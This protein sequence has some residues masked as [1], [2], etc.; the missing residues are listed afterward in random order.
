MATIGAPTLAG[1]PE[2][3]PGLCASATAVPF[4]VEDEAAAFIKSLDRFLQNSFGVQIGQKYYKIPRMGG[5][6]LDLA[7]PLHRLARHTLSCTL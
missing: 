6:D 7:C 5:Q 3:R 4:I 1:A 2:T